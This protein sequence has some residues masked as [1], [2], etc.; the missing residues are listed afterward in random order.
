M[1]D[2]DPIE[3]NYCLEVSSPG[4]ERELL[5]EEHFD[6]FLGA[7]V[8]LKLHRPDENGS[9]ELKGTLI[10]HDRETVTVILENGTQSVINKK[11]AVYIKLD[12]FNL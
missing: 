10:A 2:L 8:M 5:K 6:A 12:D 3:Q 11:D 9:R 1:D 4:I 7:P